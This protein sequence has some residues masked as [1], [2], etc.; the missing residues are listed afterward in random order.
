MK[1]TIS[2]IIASVKQ[3]SISQ[4]VPIL[5]IAAILIFIPDMSHAKE[6]TMPWDGFLS[7]VADTLTGTT[8]MTLATIGIA[9]CG[10]G[11]FLGNGGDGFRKFLI[12][13]LGLCIVLWAGKA[14]KMMS[15]SAK[16]GSLPVVT[17]QVA[18]IHSETLN[19]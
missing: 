10:I 7:D 14:V 5:T 13:I 3:I 9:I 8:A 1:N 15:D 6:I 16:Q 2:N 19:S 4:L 18:S 11:L 17:Q 12:V